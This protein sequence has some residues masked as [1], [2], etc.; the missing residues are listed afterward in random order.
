ME[1]KVSKVDELDPTLFPSSNRHVFLTI[2]GD[3]GNE[4]DLYSSLPAWSYYAEHCYTQDQEVNVPLLRS[5]FSGCV[6][7]D[8]DAFVL[9][10][11]LDDVSS[12]N[13]SIDD[14]IHFAPNT[15]KWLLWEDPILGF[16]SPST[17]LSGIDLAS[18]YSSLA[19]HL[20]KY[21]SLKSIKSLVDETLPEKSLV[22]LPFNS[23]LRFPL[24]LAE[25]LKLKAGLRRELHDAY[26]RRDWN[27]LDQLGGRSER[28]RL[29]LL[30][31]RVLKLSNYH[32]EMV[33]PLENW[34]SF[35]SAQT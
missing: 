20:R 26:R 35:S 19:I 13:Q 25:V 10:S 31:K 24:L 3:E 15:S 27:R 2:W 12:S 21:L 32:R 11:R 22:D 33:S 29:S 14:K 30:R 18:H 17:E 8:F 7:A 4:V 23:R 6:S 28:S 1:R 34:R 5:K 16:V 9:A